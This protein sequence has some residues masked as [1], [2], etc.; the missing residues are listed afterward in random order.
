MPLSGAARTAALLRVAFI[1]LALCSLP[2]ERAFA[3]P[4]SFPAPADRV[5]DRED[6]TFADLMRLI[7]PAAGAEAAVT[8]REIGSDVVEAFALASS[9][10]P[11]LAAVPVRADG[12]ERLAVL[13]DFGSGEYVVGLA[14]LALFDVTDA[15]RLLDAANV[16][17]G[18]G[19]AFYDP[20]RLG[21]G[22]E[23]DVLAIQSTH[24]NSGQ[25]YTTVP[26]I[27]VRADRLELIDTIFAFD[28][29]L[30]GFE[31]TQRVGLQQAAAG[32]FPDIMTTVTELT[33]LSQ[34]TCGEAALPEAGTRRIAVTYRWDAGA[35]RYIADSD[36][37]DVL[38][39]ESEERF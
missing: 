33:T 12:A 2:I 1:G 27:L 38:A 10:A 18:A 13:L 30:C 35:Q 31:R 26:L 22:T 37:F 25:S 29:R 16:A 8:V 9:A 17:S 32:A 3:E 39:R 23:G 6:L 21:N 28:E 14:V 34:E 24:A 7:M 36:A 20:A 4:V 15:P 19:T 11:R 5:D